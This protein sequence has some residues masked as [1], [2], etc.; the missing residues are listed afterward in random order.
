[1]VS[2]FP[3]SN[4]AV[5]ISSSE[6]RSYSSS[7]TSATTDSDAK[8]GVVVLLVVVAKVVVDA[9]KVLDDPERSVSL[10]TS[11]WLRCKLLADTLSPKALGTFLVSSIWP[12]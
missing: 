4:L 11:S 3:L 2:I 12:I 9:D 8:E 10:G 1:M 7:S 6:A 5:V